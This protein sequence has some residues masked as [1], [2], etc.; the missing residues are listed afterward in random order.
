M[1]ILS[2]IG[3]LLHQAVTVAAVTVRDHY[4]KFDCIY[5]I[6]QAWQTKKASESHATLTK[7]YEQKRWTRLDIV[8]LFATG[9][10]FL[11]SLERG[12]SFISRRVYGE[13]GFIET[14]F[15][16]YI[17]VQGGVLLGAFVMGSLL[18]HL[19]KPT[20]T[21]QL[22]NVAVSAEVGKITCYVARIIM[23]VAL[24]SFSVSGVFF[25]LSATAQIYSL[26]LVLKRK[27]VE[28]KYALPLHP[29][30]DTA[31]ASF[32]FILN[33]S[34][35]AAVS[36]CILCQDNHTP[37]T[38]PYCDQHT[39][40]ESCLLTHMHQKMQN[41]GNGMNIQHAWGTHT[42][43][44]RIGNS[45]TTITSNRAEYTLLV[46]M[47]NRPDCPACHA[48]PTHNEFRVS[49]NDKLLSQAIANYRW[50]VPATT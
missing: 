34:K 20:L 14:A 15:F 31:T 43:H 32:E 10:M 35:A 46:P 6:V 19:Y 28:I 7:T 45:M 22:E 2:S 36:Q 25:A 18:F 50:A 44:V 39:F 17:L 11:A 24:I 1:A 8:S 4:E 16:C 13:Y 37:A 9:A 12:R 27:W 3:P 49:V 21:N 48:Y 33:S 5:N 26:A 30:N 23:N 38:V 29:H 41:I 47:A 42:T 40:H